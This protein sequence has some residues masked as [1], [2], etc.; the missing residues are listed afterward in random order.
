MLGMHFFEGIER[1]VFVAEACVEQEPFAVL[2]ASSGS[3]FEVIPQEADS[4]IALFCVN[5]GAAKPG[6]WEMAPRRPP[7]SF[8]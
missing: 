5:V 1:A 7:V 4:L 8:L 2:S 6:L 3:S